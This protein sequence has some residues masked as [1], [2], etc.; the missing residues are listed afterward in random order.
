MYMPENEINKLSKDERRNVEFLVNNLIK[1]I[2]LN[3][4]YVYY[5]TP[6]NFIKQAIERLLFNGK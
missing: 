4:V 1:A 2:N 3:R 5:S 6:G